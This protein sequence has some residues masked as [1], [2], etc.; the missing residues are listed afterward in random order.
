MKAAGQTPNRLAR[1]RILSNVE[2]RLRGFRTRPPGFRSPTVSDCVNSCAS[3]SDLNI[4]DPVA[5]E[6][7]FKRWDQSKK[8]LLRIY[9]KAHSF[10]EPSIS[11][12]ISSGPFCGMNTVA[13]SSTE[14]PPSASIVVNDGPL[15]GHNWPSILPNRIA[16]LSGLTL[17]VHQ[18]Y[19]PGCGRVA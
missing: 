14:L 1:R 7:F 11:Q 3:M 2:F 10:Q 15:N 17:F 5:S 4:A 12:K 19:L 18:L 8:V 6:S 13:S 16:S 9:R